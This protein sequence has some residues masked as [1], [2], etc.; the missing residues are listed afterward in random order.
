MSENENK[1]EPSHTFKVDV[2]EDILNEAMRAVEE[3][4][5][6]GSA[7]RG[8]DE[9]IAQLEAELTA[10]TEEANQNKDKYLR[11]VADFDNFRKRALREK[12][13]ARQY[14]AENLLRDLLVILDNMERAVEAAGDA[15]QIKQG[16]KMTH[17][18]FKG[19]L[20]QHGVEILESAGN[21]FDPARH[22][23]VAHIETEEHAPGTVMAEHRRGYKFRDRLLRP[24]MVSVAKA[25][26][27]SQGNGSANDAPPAE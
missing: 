10:K 15:E 2:D 7:R 1:N 16:V 8:L 14:G 6:S 13:E 23:A 22:E 9:K 5:P 25:L 3:K 18:Q 27:P 26:S 4:E 11:S 24:A 21:P 12:D 20:K 17:D 19:I